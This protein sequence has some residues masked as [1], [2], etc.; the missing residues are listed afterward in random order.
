M[1]TFSLTIHSRCKF[2]H[3]C[4]LLFILLP[5]TLAQITDEIGQATDITTVQCTAVSQ[6]CAVGFVSA[7][8]HHSLKERLMF[9][10]NVSQINDLVPLC[11]LKELLVYF[12]NVPPVLNDP[13][14]IPF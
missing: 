7:L 11:T 13:E 3:F 1:F 10:S 4:T 6:L 14:E 12:A 9:F 5:S 2:V 8:G